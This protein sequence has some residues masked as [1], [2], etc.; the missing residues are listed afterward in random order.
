MT[1]T[2]PPILRVLRER[3]GLE[4]FRGPQREGFVA[5]LGGR[6]VLVWLP[7]GSG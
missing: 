4:D 5:V 7:R 6:E 2:P 3:I 1:E